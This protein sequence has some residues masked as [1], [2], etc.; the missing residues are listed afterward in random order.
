MLL[1]RQSRVTSTLMR[2]KSKA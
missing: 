1:A 2:A